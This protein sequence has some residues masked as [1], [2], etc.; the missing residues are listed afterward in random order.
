MVDSAI[1]TRYAKA[2]FKLSKEKSILTEALKDMKLVFETFEEVQELSEIMQDP[3]LKT[4]EKIKVINSVF[5]PRIGETSLLFLNL[6]VNNKREFY[7][8]G[9]TRYFLS[10][11]KKEKGIKTVVLTTAH[12]LEKKQ[13]ENITSLIRQELNSEIELT[14]IVNEKLVGGFIIKVDD[15]QYDSSVRSELKKIKKNFLEATIDN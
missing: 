5:K 3:V 8:K 6:I 13:K 7:I 1:N 14:K 11:V 4:A 10:L 12:E 9:I 15:N 2:L